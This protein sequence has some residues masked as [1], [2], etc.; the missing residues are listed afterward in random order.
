MKKSLFITL[1]AL[2]L[3]QVSGEAFAMQQPTATQKAPQKRHATEMENSQNDSKNAPEN[4]KQKT[5]APET[6]ADGVNGATQATESSTAI[7]TNKSDVIPYF[8]NCPDDTIMLILSFC[9]VESLGKA[10]QTCNRFSA[11]VKSPLLLQDMLHNLLSCD[12]ERPLSL[13][14]YTDATKILAQYPSL[15][16]V[17]VFKDQASTLIAKIA[18]YLKLRD[19]PTTER[20]IEEAFKNGF[21]NADIYNQI[22]S[23]NTFTRLL[24][25]YCCTNIITTLYNRGELRITNPDWIIRATAIG[26]NFAIKIGHPEKFKMLFDIASGLEVFQTQE[27][28]MLRAASNGAPFFATVLM[29]HKFSILETF[30]NENVLHIAIEFNQNKFVEWVLSLDQ[31]TVVSKLLIQRNDIGETPIQKALSKKNSHIISLLID[32][33]VDIDIIDIMH[34]I[35]N[36][37]FEIAKY[38]ITTLKKRNPRLNLN[39]PDSDGNTPLNHAVESGNLSMVQFILDNGGAESIN[40]ANT[41]G[42]NPISMAFALDFDEIHKLLVNYNK[43]QPNTKK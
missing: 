7:I 15:Q 39:T 25:E 3:F 23:W 20:Y 5:D 12:A 35:K 16:N 41:Y 26:S 29:S 21:D 38:F 22:N 10:A 19:T 43:Q 36:K 11:I 18:K 27:P 30:S 9:D 14:K 31:K 4:K 42:I 24:F 1:L 28:P 33:G 34:A 32:A 40:I 2:S 8:D 37:S 17:T 13:I 6:A